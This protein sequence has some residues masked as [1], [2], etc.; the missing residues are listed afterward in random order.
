MSKLNLP[1]MDITHIFHL[2]RFLD[3]NNNGV[4]REREREREKKKTG[5]TDYTKMACSHVITKK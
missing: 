2:S 5:H 3:E 1:N 4:K